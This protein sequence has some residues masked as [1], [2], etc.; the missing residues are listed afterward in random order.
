M[1]TAVIT[2][3]TGEGGVDTQSEA[4]AIARLNSNLFLIQ[5]ASRIADEGD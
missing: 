3:I 5:E 4:Q 2:T 1:P